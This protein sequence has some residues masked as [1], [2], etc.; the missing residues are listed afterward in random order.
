MCIGRKT[1]FFQTRFFDRMS[2]MKKRLLT[3][4]AAALFAALA[5]ETPIFAGDVPK[6]IL[7]KTSAVFETAESD[8]GQ[9]LFVNAASAD[10][11]KNRLYSFNQ[12][13]KE[14]QILFEP[15]ADTRLRFIYG[16]AFFA[17]EKLDKIISS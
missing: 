9:W 10:D 2:E 13:T 12:K 7:E 1:P 17:K 15:A 8:D 3:F 6:E 4:I 11:Q 14:T 16:M 5:L